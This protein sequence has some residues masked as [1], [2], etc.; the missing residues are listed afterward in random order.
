MSGIDI[1]DVLRQF[2]QDWEREERNGIYDHLGRGCGAIII[3][4]I[5]RLRELEQAGYLGTLYR[6]DYEV[7]G[8]GSFP[9]DMLRYTSSWPTE[10]GDAISLAQ[11]FDSLTETRLHKIRLTMKH[12]DPEPQ[13]AADRWEAKFRWRVVRLVQTVKL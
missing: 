11:T 8:R 5:N 13:L 10:E 12:R 1:Y 6:T 2:Q 7:E 9:M 4:I 3:P